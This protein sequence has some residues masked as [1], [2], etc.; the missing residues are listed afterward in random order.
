MTEKQ[1]HTSTLDGRLSK[2][3]KTVAAFVSADIHT[4]A[5][6]GCDHGYVA[7]HL[8]DRRQMRHVIAMDVRPGPLQKAREHIACYGMADKVETR[9]SDGVEAL[10]EG[11]SECLIIAGMGGKLTVDILTRGLYVIRAMKELILQPQSE[12]F[13]VREFLKEH[14]FIIEREAMLCEEGKYYTVLRAVPEAE[15]HGPEAAGKKKEAGKSLNS[16]QAARIRRMEDRYGPYLLRTADPVLK[17]FL[18]KEKAVAD[19]ILKALTKAGEETGKL[20]ARRTQILDKLADIAFV[21]AYYYGEAPED[22]YEMQ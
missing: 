17:Q 9:L 12:L 13:L 10:C 4:A 7:L 18:A 8:A 5:D 3:L 11:E 6:V 16:E 2:R 20:Q 15:D 14:G 21:E 19:E 1:N 22:A